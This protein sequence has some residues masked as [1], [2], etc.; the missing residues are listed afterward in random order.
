LRRV[1]ETQQLE[2]GGRGDSPRTLGDVLYA[3]SS[4]AP[5]PEK[6]WLELVQSI[7]AGEQLALHALYERTHRLVF[8]L[9]MRITSNR[10][11][12]EELTLD[13]YH[14]LWRRASRYDPANGTVLGWIMNQARSRA[15]DRL[16]FEQRKKRVDPNPDAA[17]LTIDA[18]DYRDVL[19]MK[20]QSLA[21]RNALTVLTP[22]ERQAVEAAFFS[23]LTHAEVAARLNEP[24]G[25]IK[26][27]IRSALHKLRHALAEGTGRP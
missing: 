25:T 13:V 20:E 12:A 4:K 18:P 27:R 11:T 22:K 21:L 1:A 16:R 19:E 5:V 3:Q 17:L 24:L 2:Q 7:A 23:D 6:D 9:I 26:T 10:E 14:D 15:I 8:T